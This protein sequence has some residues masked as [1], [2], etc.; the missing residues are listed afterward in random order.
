MAPIPPPIAGVKNPNAQVHYGADD[1]YAGQSVGPKAKIDNFDGNKTTGDK[2]DRYFAEQTAMREFL[3]NNPSKDHDQ[4]IKDLVQNFGG[5][6]AVQ[7]QVHLLEAERTKRE[8]TDNPMSREEEQTRADA[9]AGEVKAAERSLLDS[10]ETIYS[11]KDGVMHTSANTA[12]DNA[13]VPHVNL[14]VGPSSTAAPTAPP[15][16]TNQTPPAGAADITN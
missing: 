5:T 8:G 2:D 4:R 1:L 6:A 9:I 16:K 7:Y 10:G 13:E 15:A 3:I 11:V 14:D 12:P